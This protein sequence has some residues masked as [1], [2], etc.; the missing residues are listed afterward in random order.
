MVKNAAGLEGRSADASRAKP[1][2]ERRSLPSGRLGAFLS[3]LF[4]KCLPKGGR[5]MPPGRS[6][7]SE[8]GG[9]EEKTQ[10]SAIGQTRSVLESSL[11]EVPSEGRSA[12]A[13]RAKPSLE[14]GCSEEKAQK[15]AIGQIRSAFIRQALLRRGKFCYNNDQSIAS[16]TE[17][18]GVFSF[19]SF[20]FLLYFF[21]FFFSFRSLRQKFRPFPT[22]LSEVF[23]AF[24]PSPFSC[25]RF[26]FSG[27]A[28]CRRRAFLPASDFLPLLRSPAPFFS[29]PSLFS[30]AA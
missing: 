11:R 26:L 9:S 2:L 7:V 8:R 17:E 21:F 10:K 24:S 19:P 3:L 22:H 25:R 27:G 15:S 28:E 6:R 29:P 20:F 1:S 14:R 30:R 13:S 12:D 18:S 5:L 4:E 23:H 16:L